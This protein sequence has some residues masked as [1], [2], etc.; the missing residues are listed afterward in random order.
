MLGFDCVLA[1]NTATFETPTFAEIGA[2]VEATLSGTASEAEVTNRASNGNAQ[3][4]PGKHTWEVSGTIKEDGADAGFVAIRDAYL[5]RTK[6]DIWALDGPTDVAG[7]QG[8]R[9][10]MKV[11]E[12][13][14]TEPEDGPVEYAFKLKPCKSSN[15][16]SWDVVEE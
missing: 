2:V 9:A 11:F 4:E 15:P 3:F 12:W 8:L 1:R 6:L 14:R 16:M 10:D 5:N 13:T 7:S